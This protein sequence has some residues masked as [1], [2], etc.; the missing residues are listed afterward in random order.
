MNMAATQPQSGG[1]GHVRIE[2]AF[3][4]ER[5]LSW[6]LAVRVTLVTFAVIVTWVVIENGF[7]QSFFMLPLITLL[8]VLLA[9]PYWLLCA[10]RLRPWHNLVLP[11][12]YAA[13][14]TFLALYPNPLSPFRLPLPIYLRFAN[15][16][17][18]FC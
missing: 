10:G 5:I 15:E 12:L 8:A 6:R 11:M 3:L 9:I 16:V 14:I 7:P 1:Q 4:N 17:Y 2:A 13:L 18:F